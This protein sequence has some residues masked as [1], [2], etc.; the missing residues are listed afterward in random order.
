[1]D[2]FYKR[3]TM[4]DGRDGSCKACKCKSTRIYSRVDAKPKPPRLNCYED[5]VVDGIRRGVVDPRDV[6]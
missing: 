4:R 2:A 1:M 5:Y 6:Y 3:K